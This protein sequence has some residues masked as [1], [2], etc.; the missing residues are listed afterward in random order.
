M[1]KNSITIL[2]LIIATLF[3]SCGINKVIFS[4]KPVDKLEKIALI[5]TFIEFSTA[6]EDTYMPIIN[7]RINSVSGELTELLQKNTSIYRDSLGIFLSK[8]CNCEVL[9]GESLHSNPGFA[10]LRDEFN[11]PDALATNDKYFPFMFL[12]SDDFNPFKT[13]DAFKTVKPIPSL[14]I[15]EKQTIQE[16]CKNLNV[17]Y[18]IVSYT[19]L[20]PYSKNIIVA[21]TFS[22][23]DKDGDYIAWANKFGDG[24]KIKAGKIEEF[25]KVVNSFFIIIKP[26]ISEVFSK[27]SL[28]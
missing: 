17:N 15:N 22:L 13:I 2:G 4:S 10:K 23:F 8:N 5:S 26:I 1:K 28:N 12:P 20:V 6:S 25:H 14:L 21:T 3:N 11:F 19:V 27:Y 24:G 18:I 16:I 9:Y 7:E